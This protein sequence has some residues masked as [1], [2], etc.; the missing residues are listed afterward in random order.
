MKIV[1]ATDSFKGSIS[2]EGA[3]RLIKQ[4]MEAVLDAEY[5]P[6]PMADGGEGT[7]EAMVA[8]LQGEL[9]QVEV[10]GPL[11]EKVLASFGL[12]RDRKTA[13]IEMAAAS[14]LPLVPEP[15][16]N[17]EVTTTYGT[18]ELIRA[19]LEQGCEELIIGIGG[20]AT[21]D[22]GAGMIQ[23]LGGR[24]LRE[25]GSPIPW[26]GAGL[27]ELARIDLSGLDPRLE[28]VRLQ[29]ACD[30]DNPLCGP[31]GAAYV[32]GPQKGAT[33]QQ[34]ERLD[35]A[36]GHYAE[37][38]QRELGKDVRHIPGAGAAGGLG[39]GFLAFTKAKLRPGVEIV[40]ETVGLEELV[41]DADLVIT[42]EGAIDGQ[43]V[44]GKTPV[45]V[46][47]V[48]AKYGCPVIAIVGSVGLGSHE[49]HT[50]GIT[51]YF[52]LINRPMSLATAMAETEDLILDLAS[53]IGR[54][55][56]ALVRL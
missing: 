42:G 1:I 6:V 14:G 19:A 50:Q 34:V 30:V 46:A 29:V 28:Q 21:N 8:A 39:A 55:V 24:L 12:V 22:G 10:T 11:G 13:I 17:P 25:D 43:S 31:K 47:R 45:G 5:I 15:L 7:V 48:A 20:S 9:R 33:P 18:G 4:G 2:A 54:L 38:I 52:S 53:Q 26:G 16:R 23:A 36:L 44:R 3:C 41:K 40:M 32:Y 35:R 37:V 51:A 56:K 27:L 49:V